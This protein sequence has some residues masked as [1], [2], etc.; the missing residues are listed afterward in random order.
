M[1]ALVPCQRIHLDSRC[2]RYNPR[3]PVQS[4]PNLCS[5][6]PVAMCGWPPACTSGLTR[7]ATAGGALPFW[8]CRAAS[9]P[10]A[11]IV[12]CF[13]NLVL[14]FAH[15]GKDDAIA[16]N[17]NSAQ[18]FQLTAGNNIE[19]TPHPR[20]MVQDGKIAVRLNGKAQRM[21]QRTKAAVQFLIRIFDSRAAI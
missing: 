3:A 9:P 11:A 4:K 14:V 20:Q 13:A 8:T 17:A 15:A 16:A 19:P 12:Q 21:R 6:R 18:V 2:A 5:W 10:S 1:C 7:M